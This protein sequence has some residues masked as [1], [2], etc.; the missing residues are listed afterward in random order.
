M[1]TSFCHVF[2]II[3]WL[4]LMRDS[5]ET[6]ANHGFVPYV[7]WSSL[8]LEMPCERCRLRLALEVPGE[9]HLERV[10]GAFY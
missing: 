6:V 8:H 3:I 9:D 1:S 5:L 2:P 10:A 4:S 7:K